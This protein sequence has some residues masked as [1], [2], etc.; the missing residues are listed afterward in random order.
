[1]LV[2]ED[3]PFLIFDKVRSGTGIR[4][5]VESGVMFSPSWNPL[6]CVYCTSIW[7]AIAMWLMWMVAYWFVWI[8]AISA[9]CCLIENVVDR[10]GES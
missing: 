9:V 4:V 10:V 1:M 5:D 2:I 7:M 6:Y 8:L 3:G